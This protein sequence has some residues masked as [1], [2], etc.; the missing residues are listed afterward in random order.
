MRI[1]KHRKTHK[2]NLKQ[3]KNEDSESST[4]RLNTELDDYYL[5]LAFMAEKNKWIVKIL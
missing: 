4:Q 3:N 5:A 1:V 2:K